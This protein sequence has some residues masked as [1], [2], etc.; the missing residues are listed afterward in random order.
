MVGIDVGTTKVCTI[1][2]E[3][4]SSNN[5]RVVGVG[6]TP[7]H[8]L[9]KALVV[10]LNDARAAV[11][12]SVQEAERS[13][14]QR[15]DAAYVGITGR[16][17]TSFNNRGVISISRSDR[18][19][20]PAD[21]RRVME[22]ARSIKVSSD[23]RLLHVIPRGYAIDGQ[24]GAGSPIGLHGSR[25]DVEA[26]II[27]AATTSIQNLLKCVRGVGVDVEDLI[28]EPI[29]SAEAVL[30]NE[31]RELGVILADIGGG[32]TDI[33]VFKDG[34]IWHTSV[35]PVAG[36]QFTRDIAVGLG[37]PFDVAEEMKKKYGTAMP[38]PEGRSAMD[39]ELSTDGHGVSYQD[40]YDILRAR[41][42]EVL[43]LI[44]LELP[45][46]EYEGLVPAG[47]VLTGGSSTLPGIDRLGQEVLKLPVRVGSPT[48]M[49]GIVDALK[50]PAYATVVGLLLWAGKN[51]GKPSW[52]SRGLGRFFEKLLFRFRLIGQ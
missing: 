52:Q 21:L 36:Y 32:T 46:H 27:T 6:L 9:H 5:L 42:E 43:K 8:G 48:R 14:G 51:K 31:E 26:H 47:L 19:V 23:R 35:L 10:N 41:V 12:E 38:V 1:V 13:S 33:T 16:H 45:T 34:S 4:D 7:S 15:I 25:L 37:L 18:L 50:G 40:L 20:R 24:P 49:Y 2:G 11:R 28:L 44:V 22:S 30:T 17:I 39:T 3:V 29:A